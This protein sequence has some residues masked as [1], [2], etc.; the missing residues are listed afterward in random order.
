MCTV[1]NEI[2]ITVNNNRFCLQSIMVSPW[3]DMAHPLLS[4]DFPTS[5]FTLPETP[6]WA[7]GLWQTAGGETTSTTLAT[8]HMVHLK[9]E[10]CAATLPT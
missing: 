7:R 6:S 3:L 8:S 1:H 10:D 2:I 4:R 9:T 5:L